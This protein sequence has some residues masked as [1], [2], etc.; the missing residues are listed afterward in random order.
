MKHIYLACY[1]ISDEKRLYRVH[2]KMLGFGDPLQYS[3]FVC[4]LSKT[5]KLIMISEVRKLIN[6]EQDRFLLVC[7]GPER[8]D[9]SSLFEFYGLKNPIRRNRVKIF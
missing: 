7:L 3:V 1:D 4:S 5:E 8:D 9:T 2:K 6:E